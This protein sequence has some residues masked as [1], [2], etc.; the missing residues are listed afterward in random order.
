MSKNCQKLDIFFKTNVKNC[1]FLND[2][3]GNFLKQMS[4]FWQLFEIQMAIFRRVSS[5]YPPSP[6]MTLLQ[7]S[8]LLFNLEIL[9]LQVV[10]GDAYLKMKLLKFKNPGGRG[11]NGN[12]CDSFGWISLSECDHIFTI[13]LDQKDG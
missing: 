9:H 4:S 8:V 12:P 6:D 10:A 11:A 1:L 7:C 3:F 2:N 5:P 13:C